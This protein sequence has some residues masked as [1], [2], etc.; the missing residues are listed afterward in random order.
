MRTMTWAGEDPKGLDFRGSRRARASLRVLDPMRRHSN[1]SKAPG[2]QACYERCK[3]LAQF[4]AGCY[5]IAG[6]GLLDDVTMLSYEQ[7]AIDDESQDNG[8][9]MRS[10]SPSMTI[11]WLS[12]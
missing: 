5:M 8:A 3:R 12:I 6:L 9:S 1:F 11:T 4:Y 10:G 2:P 7:M